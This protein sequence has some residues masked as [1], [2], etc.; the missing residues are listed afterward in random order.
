MKEAGCYFIFF[1]M[2]SADN[3]TL[4]RIKKNITVEQIKNAINL[5]KQV[6]IISV[7]AFI[8]GLP[9]DTEEQVLKAIE[10]AEE[11]DLYSVTF[12][13]AVPFPGT[14]LREMALKNEFGMRIISDNWDHYGKQDPG[15]LESKDLPWVKRKE[16]Q[17]FAY[18]RNPK[19]QIDIY[20]QRLSNFA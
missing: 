16:L 12:P 4:K 5:T 2:E 18:L 9:G 3:E 19:K 8:I 6:G 7:G 15:V 14:E 17:R 10:L 1:G 20:L 11:L 13:I